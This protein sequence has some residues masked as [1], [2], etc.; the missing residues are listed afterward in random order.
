M[1]EGHVPRTASMTESLWFA[2]ELKAV[3]SRSALALSLHEHQIQRGLT[4]G[5]FEFHPFH[6]LVD[7]HI[8]KLLGIWADAFHIQLV[9]NRG[10]IF[11]SG[12]YQPFLMS[13]FNSNLWI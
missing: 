8:W 11:I 7:A 9:S 1:T 2:Q 5:G 12:K 10:G 6:S 4:A 13:Q 3:E